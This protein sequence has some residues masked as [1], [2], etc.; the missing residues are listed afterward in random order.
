MLCSRLCHLA[1]CVLTAAAVLFAAPAWAVTLTRGPYLTL[2]TRTSVT[3]VW[4]TDI[5]TNCG[6][7]IGPVGGSTTVLA[8]PALTTVCV[9]TAGGLTP[10]GSYTYTPQANGVALG[11]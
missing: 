9:V 11:S 8:G 6:L 4:N 5:A 7:R 10:G 2:L 1:S 3:V